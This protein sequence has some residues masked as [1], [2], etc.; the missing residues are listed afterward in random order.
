MRKYLKLVILLLGLSLA[1]TACGGGGPSTNLKVDMVEFMFDPAEYVIP[2]G[3]EITLDLSNNG[4]VLHEFVIMK[5]GTNVG[6]DFGDEDEENIYWEAELNPGTSGTFTFTA[7]SEPGEYQIVC[8]TE[9]HYLAGMLG[10]LIVVT[11]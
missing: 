3:Q 9:G 11:E 4:A 1:L 2:A 8:G 10:S 6:E 5:F 7:P